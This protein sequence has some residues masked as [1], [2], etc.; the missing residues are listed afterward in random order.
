LAR[1]GGR[2]SYGGR[3]QAPSRRIRL[4]LGKSVSVT[5]SSHRFLLPAS[6]DSTLEGDQ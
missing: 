3:W 4:D 6:R 1:T 5:V 2:V